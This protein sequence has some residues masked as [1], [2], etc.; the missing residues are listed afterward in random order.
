MGVIVQ[1]VE[2]ESKSGNRYSVVDPRELR[3]IKDGLSD[4]SDK[5]PSLDRFDFGEVGSSSPAEANTF[6]EQ[7]MQASATNQQPQVEELGD[8]EIPF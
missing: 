5:V 4:H 1:V 8:E 3:P 2:K 6:V 7:S